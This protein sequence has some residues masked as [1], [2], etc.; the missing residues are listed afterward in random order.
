MKYAKVN[1]GNGEADIVMAF[2]NSAERSSF[3]VSYQEE[4]LTA[5]AAKKIG[6]IKIV[7]GFGDGADKRWEW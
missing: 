5:K 4:N 2:E 3:C 6:N 1:M 7:Q